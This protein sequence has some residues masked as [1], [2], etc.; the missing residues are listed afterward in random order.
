ME[1]QITLIKS[2]WSAVKLSPS[3]KIEKNT[4][5]SINKVMELWS[6]DNFQQILTSGSYYQTITDGDFHPGQIMVN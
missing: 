3:F 4:K 6:W 5:D 2:L 1:E